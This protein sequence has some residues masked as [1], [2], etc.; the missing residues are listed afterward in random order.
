MPAGFPD[1]PRGSRVEAPFGKRRVM[2][3]V[4]DAGVEPKEGVALKNLTAVFDEE[5]LVTDH[6][7]QL[8]LWVSDYY[9]GPIGIET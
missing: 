5:P 2:G 7:L 3:V 6:L 4:V 9:I 1:V 8:A